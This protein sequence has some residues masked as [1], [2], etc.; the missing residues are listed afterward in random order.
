MAQEMCLMIRQAGQ[1]MAGGA[2][3][4][5]ILHQRCLNA[6][7]T[8]LCKDTTRHQEEDVDPPGTQTVF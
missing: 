4:S 8:P 5:G 6:I 2:C 3:V 1:H 7:L